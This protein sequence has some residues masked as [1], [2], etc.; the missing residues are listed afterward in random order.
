MPEGG[1]T[2]IAHNLQNPDE[3]VAFG[4]MNNDLD[5]IK[6]S[7]DEDKEKARQEAMIPS[8][9]S[10]EPTRSTEVV[11]RIEARSASRREAQGGARHPG[12]SALHA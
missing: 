1:K 3:V 10:V 9:E 6:A 2:D 12:A 11:E 4:L 8:S 5:T 7:M